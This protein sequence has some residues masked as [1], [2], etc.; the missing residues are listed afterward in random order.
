MAHDDGFL[1]SRSEIMFTLY[2]THERI[3]EAFSVLR[4]KK[5]DVFAQNAATKGF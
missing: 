5:K 1:P 2:F 3:L 4:G